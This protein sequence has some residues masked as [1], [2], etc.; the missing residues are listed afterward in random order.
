V[1]GAVAKRLGERLVDEP[2]L[3]DQRQAAEAG[4]ARSSKAC[5][6][7]AATASS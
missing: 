6:G 7:S 3:V 1:D 4:N 5:S 2:V